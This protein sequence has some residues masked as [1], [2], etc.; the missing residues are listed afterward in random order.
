MKIEEVIAGINE[1]SSP[2][3]KIKPPQIILS[4]GDN[5]NLSPE[6]QKAERLYKKLQEGLSMK[7]DT[8]GKPDL[9]RI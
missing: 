2:V 7:D 6:E 3:P 4:P 8:T 9:D 1:S 5:K